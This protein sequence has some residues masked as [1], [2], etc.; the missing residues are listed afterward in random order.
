MP[1]RNSIK[2][3]I[4]GGYYHL[5]NRGVEKRQ[6]FMDDQDY[7]VFLSYLKLYLLSPDPEDFNQKIHKDLSTTID[8]VA[9]CLMPNHFHLLVRQHTAKGIEE[10]MRCINIKYAMYF[11]KRHDRTGGLFQDA[12]KAVLI[13][14]DEYLMHLSRYIHCNPALMMPNIIQY[15][16]SSYHYYLTESPP[17]LKPHSVKE[18]FTNEEA[19]R[20]FINLTDIGPLAVLHN[21]AI[22]SE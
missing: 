8:L 20:Q 3:Y 12:Y 10:F 22:D 7:R 6:I 15:P 5:Y 19:Y 21:L 11:N 13:Q 9:Y 1:S 17:W 4:E 16:Y 18:L 14:N 2:S